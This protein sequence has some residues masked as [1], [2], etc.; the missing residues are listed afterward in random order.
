MA[1]ASKLSVSI[2][3]PSNDNTEDLVETTIDKNDTGIVKLPPE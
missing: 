1:A 2:S 3:K